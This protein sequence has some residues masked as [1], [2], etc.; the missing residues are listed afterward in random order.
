MRT[1]LN[2]LRWAEGKKIA[3]GHFNIA[4]FEQFK[5][6]A[7]TA[8]DLKLPVLIGVSEGERAYLGAKQVRDLLSS[9][10]G[11]YG[12]KEND[13]GFWLFLNADHTHDLA[14]VKEAAENHF[15][16]I[17]FD[18]GKLGFGEDEK[19]TVEAVKIIKD[20]HPEILVEGEMGYIGSSSEV[21]DN[22]P[23][24]AAIDESK[25]TKPEDAKKFVEA[26]GINILAPA[27]GNIHGM[28]R[29]AANPR[30]N[31][32]RIKEIKEAVGIPMVLHGGSG[33][34][35]EDFTAAI[36]AGI[37]I[38]HIST[39]IRVAWRKGLEKGLKDNPDVVAPYHITPEA[40]TEMKGVIERR[41]KLFYNL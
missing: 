30:L 40:I 7:E 33:I 27:V 18:G 37:N 10:N 5:A 34:V 8:R 20:L 9:Y 11:E 25:L 4:S 38:V 35:D 12:D 1:L 29:K 13:G 32:D 36:K 22:V 15:D 26:T 23:T 39:E 2:T 19:Q 6:V 28:F 31:I 17:L 21:W 3:L 41:M 14:K 24:G 16:E